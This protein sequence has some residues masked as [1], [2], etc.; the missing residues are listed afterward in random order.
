MLAVPCGSFGVG[1]PDRARRSGGCLSGQVL[2]ML[3][4]AID[5]QAHKH[6]H[7]FLRNF[8]SLHV[9]RFLNLVG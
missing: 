2:A 9:R 3:A 4:G 1:Q 5:Q 7:S 6:T 8:G